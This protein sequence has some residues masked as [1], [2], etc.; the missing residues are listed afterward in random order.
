MNRP[1]FKAT[2]RAQLLAAP[3]TGPQLWMD[4]TVLHDR[5]LRF[6]RA[7]PAVLPHFA[8]KCNPD[9]QV[10]QCLREAGAGFEIASPDELRLMQ[11]LG[12]PAADLYYSNPVK[13]REAIAEAVAA[14]VQWYVVDCV[15]ELHKVHALYPQ[16][17]FYL[18]L[19]TDN[20][21]AQVALSGKFGAGALEAEAVLQAALA[22]GADLAGVTFHAG[23]QCSRVENWLSGIAAAK[24]LFQ[25]MLAL[26]LTP[27]LLNL[28]GGFPAEYDSTVPSIETLGRAINDALQD[29]PAS[30]RIMAE[31]GRYLVAE[32]GGLLCRV[33]GTTRRG[34]QRWAYLDVGV[35]NGL[36][37]SI[38]GFS[39]AIDASREGPRAAWTMAGPTCDSMDICATSQRL[40]AGLQEGDRLWIHTA[41]AYSNACASRFNGFPLLPVRLIG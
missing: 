37:E 8:V 35:F 34:G 30:V 4:R 21:G 12:V 29:I 5:V 22:C 9:P 15:E 20:Q 28:G 6:R 14:G 23:S 40:P 27:R 1:L 3:Y 26:G 25:R 17:S 41:G 32:A 13:A 36:L 31:P 18:R 2:L 16:A 10:L 11:E 39:Y 24:Q 19:H 33:I 7:L 38:T